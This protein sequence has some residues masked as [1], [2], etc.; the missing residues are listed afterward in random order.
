MLPVR[1][2]PARRMT[3]VVGSQVSNDLWQSGTHSG[4]RPFEA[5]SSG[6]A[7]ARR[8]TASPAAARPATWTR[9]RRSPSTT[10]ASTTVAP[11]YRAVMTATIERSPD[12]TASRKAR[13][14]RALRAPEPTASAQRGGLVPMR[15]R[16]V[17]TAPSRTLEETTL[18]ASRG[19]RPLPAGAWCRQMSW[20]AIAPPAPIARTS[21]RRPGRLD[22]AE[23]PPQ[24]G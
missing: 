20:V 2:P 4:E 1:A 3:L 18:P 5:P 13:F 8:H 17:T 15:R 21:A 12:R 6:Y 22:A 23:G 24:R 16:R 10:H 9:R 19:A 11:G 14:A 7:R